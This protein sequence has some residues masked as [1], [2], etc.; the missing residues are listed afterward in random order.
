MFVGEI[1]I[2][3]LAEIFDR[4]GIIRASCS[5]FCASRTFF[6]PE[7]SK[8]HALSSDNYLPSPRIIRG[9][10]SAP[11]AK[12]NPLIFRATSLLQ[13]VG[14]VL[15]P[16]GNPNIFSTII[17]CFQR[18]FMVHLNLWIGYAEK[19][20]MQIDDHLLA[21]D[22]PAPDGVMLAIRSHFGAPI[23]AIYAGKITSVDCSEHSQGERDVP[24]RGVAWLGDFWT[25]KKTIHTLFG[26][27]R[28]PT[29]AC[30]ARA[31]IFVFGI[32]DG[33]PRSL[34]FTHRVSQNSTS[35]GI[36]GGSAASPLFYLNKLVYGC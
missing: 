6:N 1:E 21:V 14:C 17:Q 11:S 8:I 18:T 13:P 10:P 7:R 12:C 5:L 31:I 20:S 36:C 26:P 24:L 9:F 34:V 29:A 32:L 2:R 30:W 28:H 33:R 3:E 19:K 16:G 25:I 4:S 22:N 23:I 15:R 35:N 27:T